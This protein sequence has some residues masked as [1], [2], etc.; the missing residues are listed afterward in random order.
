[1]VDPTTKVNFENL[2]NNM[3]LLDIQK[4][5]VEILKIISDEKRRKDIARGVAM[6]VFLGRLKKENRPLIAELKTLERKEQFLSNHRQ[7]K[8]SLWIGLGSVFVGII[9]V[10]ASVVIA[11]YVPTH[12]RITNEH[13]QIEA[14]YKNLVTNQDIFISNSN[15][16]RNLPTSDRISD[17]PELY[18]E[19]EISGNTRKILQN[20]FGLMQYR[21]FLY[22]LQQ[23]AIL[24][25]E[26]GQMRYDFITTGQPFSEL[27]STTAYLDS[28][29]Y[30]ALDGKETKFNY[31]KDTECLQYFF[32]YSFSF[33]TIDGRGKAPECSNE[34]LEARLLNHFGYLPEDTPIWLRPHLKRALNTREPRLG[35]KLIY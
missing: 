31:Q 21:F 17:L 35:D 1:M 2:F 18:I 23:T 33:L 24:N 6:P 19:D 34:T 30:L 27:N 11:F 15:K 8:I 12:Q 14:V 16:M 29:K 20:T 22:Y 26:V 3:K 9:A 32:E 10:I 5:I 25:S 13:T 28:M 7:A 4:R